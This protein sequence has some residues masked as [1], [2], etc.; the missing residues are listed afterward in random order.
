MSIYRQLIS[1]VT[2]GSTLLAFCGCPSNESTTEVDDNVPPVQF[3]KEIEIDLEPAIAKRIEGDTREAIKIL[4][5]LADKH[6]QS[7]EVLVQLGRTLMEA[8]EFPLAAFRFEEALSKGA[9]AQVSKEAAEAHYLSSDFESA[10][11]RYG[12]YLQGE[13]G[14]PDS[15]L[16]FARLLARLGR[17]TE[18]INA[19]VKA[20]D[21][22]SADDCRLMGNLFLEKKL[23]P[24]SKHW[25]EESVRRENG[26]SPE[27]L[28]GLLQV[29]IS[30][31]NDT[32]T[33]S[34]ILAVEKF[35]SGFLETTNL[36]SYCADF[37]R[38]KRLA[39]LISRG[40]D[41]RSMS[42][43]ELAAGLLA[44][45]FSPSHNQDK[46]ISSGPKFFSSEYQDNRSAISASPEKE[47]Q[48]DQNQS[49]ENISLAAAFASP[50][51]KI[52]EVSGATES[53][54]E[55]A[56]IAFIDSKYT[57]SLMH[58]RDALK[59]DSKNSSA[60][61]LCSQAHFQLGEIDA[62]EMTILEAIRHQ[63]L[64]TEFRLEYLRIARETLPADRYLQELEKAREIFP[65]SVEI[66]W[67]LAR[68]YH[69]IEKMPVTASILYRKVVE[70]AP[71]DSS[72]AKQAKIE[73][74]K[75]EKP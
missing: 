60:W 14:D 34:L 51:E 20:G 30:E 50:I 23:F 1:K 57:L 62:A 29:S 39:D 18:S 75:I 38:R 33:E 58:A 53:P 15:Q 54:L 9:N 72:I 47:I 45:S 40:I 4:N 43:T 71:E 8:R 28:Y 56:R 2:L 42:I 59:G 17:K 37:I 24:Q 68:R 44:G 49:G 6:P 55:L 31:K 41:A 52:N 26:T 74:I 65:D 22:A 48:F 46:I 21:Q 27:S 70:V 36:A 66:L 61:A 13:P 7:V 73:L 12:E 11:E 64:D 10:T 69:L 63:P 19:F 25:F 5:I 32:V 16:R 3:A 35:Q 67:E